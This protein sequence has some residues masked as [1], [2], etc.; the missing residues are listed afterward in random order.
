MSCLTFHVRTEIQMDAHGFCLAVDEIVP[1]DL[2]LPDGTEQVAGRQVSLK[3]RVALPDFVY[4]AFALS[5]RAHRRS[6]PFQC[7]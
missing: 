6:R 1:V 3:L 7:G 4:A 5:W 2:L